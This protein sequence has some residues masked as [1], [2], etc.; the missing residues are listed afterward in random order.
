ML[1]DYHLVHHGL[2]ETFHEPSYLVLKIAVWDRGYYD[3]YIFIIITLTSCKT[4][5]NTK[6]SLQGHPWWCRCRNYHPNPHPDCRLWESPKVIMSRGRGRS[7]Q[8]LCLIRNNSTIFHLCSTI[9][10]SN[11]PWKRDAECPGLLPYIFKIVQTRIGSQHMPN[12]HLIS[13]NA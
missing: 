8:G 5:G 4:L 11:V 9:V 1:T 3:C 12:Q 10:M 6:L 2:F 7:S 13:S